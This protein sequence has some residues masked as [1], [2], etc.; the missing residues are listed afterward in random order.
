LYQKHFDWVKHVVQQLIVSLE[1]SS[2][3]L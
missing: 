1:E 3:C 2:G